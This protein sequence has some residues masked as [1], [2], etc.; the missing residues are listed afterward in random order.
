MAITFPTAKIGLGGTGSSGGWLVTYDA[1]KFQTTIK[2]GTLFYNGKYFSLHDLIGTT[3]IGDEFGA[4][5]TGSAEPGEHIYIKI[6]NATS[7]PNETTT[8]LKITIEYHTSSITPEL[9]NINAPLIEYIPLALLNTDANG[10]VIVIDLR[11]S[12]MVNNFSIL[13]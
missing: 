1:V 12:F 11:P 2:F 13:A 6:N 9:I 5:E 10:N 4:S 3:R 7:Q 8:S